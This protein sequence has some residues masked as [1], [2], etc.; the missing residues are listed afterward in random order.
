MVEHRAKSERFVV[1]VRDHREHGVCRVEQVT[2]LLFPASCLRILS[3]TT[4]VRPGVCRRQL[5]DRAVDTWNA[6]HCETVIIPRGV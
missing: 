3:H 6:S 1:R 5:N 2:G 4:V